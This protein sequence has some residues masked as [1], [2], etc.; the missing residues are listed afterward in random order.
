MNLWLF[1]LAVLDV[2]Q[3]SFWDEGLSGVRLP[4]RPSV[5]ISCYRISSKTTGWICLTL[6]RMSPFMSNCAS[7][8]KKKKK[9]PNGRC[10]PSLIKFSC[11][12]IS[13]ETT[14]QIRMKLG[15][16]LVCSSQCL[17]VNTPNIFGQSPNLTQ[18]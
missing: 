13:A 14:G 5:N 6:V 9:N 16:L 15:F 3:R 4:V 2:D 18:T 17:V 7:T 8:G 12:R 10:R 1:F 11:D